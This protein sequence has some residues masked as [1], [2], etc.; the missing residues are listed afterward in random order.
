MIHMEAPQIII[1]SLQILGLGM[2]LQAHGESKM[3]TEN[4]WATL[5]ATSISVALLNW[6]GFYD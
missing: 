2:S 6:G 1:T 4:F 5:I 3:K